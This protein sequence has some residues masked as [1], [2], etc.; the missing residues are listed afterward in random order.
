MLFCNSHRLLLLHYGCFEAASKEV[1][2]SLENVRKLM[3]APD[4]ASFSCDY[5]LALCAL[6]VVFHIFGRG[7][8]S[9]EMYRMMGVSLAEVESTMVQV[10]KG[11]VLFRP[12]HNTEP[13]SAGFFSQDQVI[14]YGVRFVLFNPN[15]KAFGGC[16]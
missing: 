1:D 15:P 5:T 12:L 11:I 4:S 9:R 8:D 7:A 13:A 14:W 3:E 16:Y 2:N 6:P 10:M